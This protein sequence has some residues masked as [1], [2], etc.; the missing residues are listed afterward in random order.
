MKDGYFGVWAGAAES[1]AG[2]IEIVTELLDLVVDGE[3][4]AIGAD[5]GPMVLFLSIEG[6]PPLPVKNRVGAMAYSLPGQSA[7]GTM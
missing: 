3:R 7:R 4:C 6:I 5:D 2:E 1:R